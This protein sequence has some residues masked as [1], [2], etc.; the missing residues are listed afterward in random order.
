MNQFDVYI[1][2][3]DPARGSEMKKIR[4][5]VII[6]PNELNRHL[7]TV[8]IAPLTQ[9]LKGYLFRVPSQFD[10][11]PGEIALDQMR[12][13]AKSRLKQKKGRLPVSTATAIK[14]LLQTMF[15]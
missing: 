3:L 5:A 8:I 15:S 7:N 9:T 12:S 1:V 4:P 14:A 13:V 2:D 10:G 11:Q 6:S